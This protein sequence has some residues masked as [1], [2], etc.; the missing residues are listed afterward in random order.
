MDDVIVV[1]VAFFVV[2]FLL[3]MS[4]DDPYWFSSLSPL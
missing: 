1:I 2:G 3:V 4:V